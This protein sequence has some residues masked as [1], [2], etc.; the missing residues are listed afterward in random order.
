MIFWKRPVHNTTASDY[1]IHDTPFLYLCVCICEYIYI[2]RVYSF[3]FYYYNIVF[4]FYTHRK[5]DGGGCYVNIM[6]LCFFFF[7]PSPNNSIDEL[8][9]SFFL[10]RYI[11][12]VGDDNCD[13]SILVRTSCGL[14]VGPCRDRLIPAARFA[15]TTKK[16]HLW[17]A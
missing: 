5:P 9:C 4:K 2:M 14:R 13:I 17:W 16:R 7:L 10:S 12:A 1:P 11:S 3:F 8:F 6:H 15:T